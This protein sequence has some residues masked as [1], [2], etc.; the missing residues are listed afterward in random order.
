MGILINFNEAKRKLEEK[1]KQR[2]NVI[3]DIEVEDLDNMNDFFL[4]NLIQEIMNSSDDR[5][6]L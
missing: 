2:A 4:H 6:D 5:E 3:N 1:K